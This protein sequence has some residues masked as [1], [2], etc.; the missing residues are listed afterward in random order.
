MLIAI[1]V[2]EKDSSDLK[3][4]LSGNG[5]VQILCGPTKRVNPY[6]EVFLCNSLLLIF[7]DGGKYATLI[8]TAWIMIL[9]S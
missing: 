4:G 7:W 6:A 1:N 3:E 8:R 9:C 2:G 5:F